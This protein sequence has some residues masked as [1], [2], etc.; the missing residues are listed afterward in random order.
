MELAMNIGAAIEYMKIGHKI[1]RPA[2]NGKNMYLYLLIFDGYEPCIVMRNAQGGDQPGWLANQ[3]DLLATD[4][5]IAQ[6]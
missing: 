2:W 5:E 3:P 6:P 1:S 4:W